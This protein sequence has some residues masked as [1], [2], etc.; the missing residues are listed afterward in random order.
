[1][2]LHP[3][4]I[5][6]K[7]G[8]NYYTDKR[9]QVE[10]G[11]CLACRAK[12]VEWLK[13]LGNWNW[14]K[15]GT[16]SFITLT[17]S[18]EALIKLNRLITLPDGTIRPTCNY[19]DGTK[20]LDRIKKQIIKNKINSKAFNKDFKYIMATEYGEKFDRCHIHIIIFGIDHIEGKSLLT[21][22]WKYGIVDIG[23]LRPGGIAY[24]AEYL[25]KNYMDKITDKAFEKI[26]IEKPK[27]KH[28]KNFENGFIEN[29]KQELIENK[30]CFL[31]KGKKIGIP[32]YYKNKYNMKKF[33]KTFENEKIEMSQQN[34]IRKGKKPTKEQIEEFIKHKTKIKHKQLIEKMRQK[35]KGIFEEHK[36][37]YDKLAIEALDRD[38]NGLPNWVP[39]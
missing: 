8:N 5:N 35:N 13:T 30:S 25:M 9:Q 31:K 27:V 17:Y 11:S 28:S 20:Y 1:M 33:A 2:C 37:N 19:Q 29:K 38:D 22:K 3:F 7:K 12:K 4:T 16:A 21:E 15:Y 23:E 14:N 32:T 39:F 6:S 18:N 26:G 24:I 34:W 10:C 36:M